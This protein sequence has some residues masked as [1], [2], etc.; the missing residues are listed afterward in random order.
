M[1]ILRRALFSM[2]EDQVL[3][4]LEAF[5]KL[6]TRKTHFEEAAAANIMD[7]V[8]ERSEVGVHIF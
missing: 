1:I 8:R 4:W 2:H 6:P 3:R 7:D 5:L